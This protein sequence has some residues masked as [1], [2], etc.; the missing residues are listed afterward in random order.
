MDITVPF[1]IGAATLAGVVVI[2]PVTKYAL[3]MYPYLFA[4]TRLSSRLGLLLDKKGY[5]ELLAATSSKEAFGLLE[6][7]YYSS[8]V[9]HATDFFSFSDA[10]D[11]DLYETY[12]W[13]HSVTPEPLQ[14]VVSSLLKRFEI[15]QLKFIKI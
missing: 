11:K 14:G 6:D 1:V 15:L 12:V 8:I 9:E 10:L 5:D 2:A 3:D 4:N 13:V 7:S